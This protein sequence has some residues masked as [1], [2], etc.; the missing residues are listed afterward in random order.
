[1]HA[2]HTEIGVY[3]ESLQ[4][5]QQVADGIGT[6]IDRI[7]WRV[8]LQSNADGSQHVVWIDTDANGA[9][10]TLDSEPDVSTFRRATIWM[11]G[12]LPIESQL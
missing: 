6:N 8:E 2:R 12:L 5:A 9:V 7:A 10:T 4:A 3:C 11:L 1:M